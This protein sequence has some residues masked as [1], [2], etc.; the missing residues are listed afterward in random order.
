[1]CESEYDQAGGLDVSNKVEAF[2]GICIGVLSDF[3][4]AILLPAQEYFSQGQP[5]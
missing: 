2:Q 1:M 5:S 3:L 4:Q